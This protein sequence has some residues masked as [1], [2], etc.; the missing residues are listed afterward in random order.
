MFIL[1]DEVHIR[2][3]NKIYTHEH[4]FSKQVSIDSRV[5]LELNETKIRHL[6]EV[7]I[8]RSSPA[9][10]DPGTSLQA[11]DYKIQ[12][13]IIREKLKGYKSFT[14][15]GTYFIFQPYLSNTVLATFCFEEMW[16]H[17]KDDP[18][19]VLSVEK[20]LKTLHKNSVEVRPTLLS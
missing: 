6:I 13:L 15:N 11:I 2:M 14:R 3:S 12:L 7:G 4:N 5:P 1:K 9:I 16:T 19:L 18:I 8:K 20:A 17:M 10:N